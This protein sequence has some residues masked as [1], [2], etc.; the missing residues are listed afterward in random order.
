M[1]VERRRGERRKPG[2]R[3]RLPGEA[4]DVARIEHENLY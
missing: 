4:V 3:R 1:P 2:N